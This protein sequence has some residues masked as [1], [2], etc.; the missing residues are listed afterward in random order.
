MLR[1]GMVLLALAAGTSAV[2]AEAVRDCASDNHEIAIVACTQLLQRNPRNAVYLY[3]RAISFRAVGRIDDAFADLNKA[4]QINSRQPEFFNVR[5]LVY[6][7]W[8]D[9]PR[10]L[11]DFNRSLQLDPRYA[12][13]Y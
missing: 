11:Q 9:Y 2:F 6:V 13:A 1:V 4:I 12:L 3:N 8:R 7:R 10:A 5:G